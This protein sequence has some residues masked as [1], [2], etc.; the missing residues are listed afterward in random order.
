MVSEKKQGFN[1]GNCF[2]TSI[3][4]HQEWGTQ[5]TGG[6]KILSS[7]LWM[8]VCI[9][10]EHSSEQDQLATGNPNLKYKRGQN[11]EHSRN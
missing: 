7:I 10:Q 1:N 5:E 9:V 11:W 8:M 3:F 4:D 2:F 6:G